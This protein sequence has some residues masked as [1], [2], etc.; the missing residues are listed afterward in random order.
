MTAPPLTITETE[1]IKQAFPQITNDNYI[2][3]LLSI[4]HRQSPTNH[5]EAALQFLLRATELPNS[6]EPYLSPFEVMSYPN[7]KPSEY[8][9]QALQYLIFKFPRIPPQLCKQV[10]EKNRHLCLLAV[11]DLERSVSYPD[12]EQV[13]YGDESYPLVQNPSGKQPNPPQITNK[14]LQTDITRSQTPETFRGW[15]EKLIL[16][17]HPLKDHPPLPEEL[18][19][20]PDVFV[21]TKDETTVKLFCPKCQSI[22]SANEVAQCMK[23]H[24]LCRRCF[25]TLVR[26]HPA[27]APKCQE[28]GALYTHAVLSKFL[29]PQDKHSFRFVPAGYRYSCD[30]PIDTVQSGICPDCFF[31]LSQ[32]DAEHVWCC[33]HHGKFYLF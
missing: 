25:Q 10:F 28:C 7:I 26:S 29:T 11:N 13:L 3:R 32:G 5:L 4:M 18:S 20:L 19:F 17:T 1:V 27:E 8:H 24:S 31:P 30:Y 15:M 22:Y 23:G 12:D 33:E 9:V 14:H 2:K 21:N 16:Q 6:L